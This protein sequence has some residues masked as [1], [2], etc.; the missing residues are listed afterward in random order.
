MADDDIRTDEQSRPSQWQAAKQRASALSLDLPEPAPGTPVYI[1]TEGLD[2][3]ALVVL[4]ASVRAFERG[5]V[6]VKLI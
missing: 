3:A 4:R 6:K 2:H 5:G 1:V